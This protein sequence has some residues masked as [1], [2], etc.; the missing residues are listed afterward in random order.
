MKQ[1]SKYQIPYPES[2]DLIKDGPSVFRFMAEKIEALFS[3]HTGPQGPR[4]PEGPQG[5]PPPVTLIGKTHLDEMTE[6]GV[7][8]QH[9]NVNA[10]LEDGYPSNFAGLL[11]VFNPGGA[12]MIYQRY[13]DYNYLDV[14]VRVNYLDSWKEWRKL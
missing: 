14:Y 10:K 6:T 5:A 9:A 8:A 11:E 12:R 7:Y 3:N 13:M 2:P 4:G 1:T